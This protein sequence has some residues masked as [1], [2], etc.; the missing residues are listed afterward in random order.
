MCFTTS[1]CRVG[2]LEQVTNV[3]LPAVCMAEFVSDSPGRCFS[4]R[5]KPIE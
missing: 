2:V 5:Q 4:S 1:F 3:C